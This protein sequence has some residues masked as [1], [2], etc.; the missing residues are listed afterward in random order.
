MQL[1]K[2]S[3]IIRKLNFYSIPTKKCNPKHN[4]KNLKT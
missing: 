1:K 3:K 4:T 2:T